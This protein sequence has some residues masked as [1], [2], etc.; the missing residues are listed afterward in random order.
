MRII[1]LTL[2]SLFLLGTYAQNDPYLEELGINTSGELNKVD[3]STINALNIT[4]RD[5]AYNNSLLAEKYGRIA[6]ELS[7]QT[8]YAEGQVNALMNISAAMLYTNRTDSAIIL[9][10]LALSIAEQAKADEL[11]IK[12][13][14]RLGSAYSFN[15]QNDIAIEEYFKAISIAETFD[16][17]LAIRS[18]VNIGHAFKLLKN[19]DKSKE[20]S[21][22]AYELGSEYEDTSVMITALNILALLENRAG[23]AEKAL[24]Y[25]EEGL[26]YARATDNLERQSQIL[27]N[28][29][30]IYF[31]REEY[32]KGFELFNESV[33]ISKVNGSY[34][35]IAIGFHSIAITYLEIGELNKSSMAA[36]SA[37]V[38]GLLS[39]NY[40]MIME[41]YAMKA[42][43]A[44]T[45]GHYQKSV[46]YLEFAYIYKD[47]LNLAQLNGAALD[48]EDTFNEQKRMIADSLQKVH[49]DAKIAHDDEINS[50]KL[51]TLYI[52]L[53]IAVFV[54][55]IVAFGIYF[56]NK[57]NKLIKEQHALVNEQKD[58]IEI[59]HQEITDSISYAQRIQE[60]IIAKAG[61]WEKISPE[62]FIL[63]KP[64]DVVSGDFYWAYN[65][66][67][68]N[69]SIWAVADCT[70]HGVPGAFMS[71]LGIGFLN[72]IVIETGTTDPGLIL[73][74][75]RDKIVA[76]LTQKGETKT[77]DGMDISICVWDKSSDTIHYA[78]ANNPLWIIRKKGCEVPEDVKKIVE[79]ESSDFV[80]LDIAPDKMPIGYMFASP[81]PFSTQ[82][83]KA[84][85]GDTILL[86]SDGFPDQFGGEKGKKYKYKTLKERM[87]EL[88][89]LP[90]NTHEEFLNDEFETWKGSEEQ[91][92]DVCIVGVKIC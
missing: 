6:Y 75:L 45:K 86:L 76:A 58:E 69:L 40:E 12:A 51:T 28:L 91:V 27:Y 42:E 18:Y 87:L 36:D 11:R 41:A 13:H 49:D 25:F 62:R 90:M 34:L 53:A 1:L 35:N 48:A 32:E 19:F 9:T 31:D 8:E 50:Q 43:V 66:E 54:I 74:K 63:F 47:S 52:L 59:Q 64:K 92:D 70:G 30:N 15:G 16:E 37:L 20:Y 23:D 7:R 82:S 38:Y 46:E 24:S 68:K 83:F 17:S 2:F 88:Q 10:Q 44:K 89:P 26:E 14:Q 61:E 78:G 72:E 57:N 22:K 56:L 5:S 33:E 80:V 55:A 71:M 60:A 65:N 29:S 4:A 73:D 81:P 84:L 67:A 39:E 21:L 77:K 79:I 3:T 85:K